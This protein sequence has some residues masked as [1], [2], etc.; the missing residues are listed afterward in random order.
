MSANTAF[1]K[2]L[3]ADYILLMNELDAWLQL[4][5]T[6]GVGP[7][8]F[9]KLLLKFGDPVAVFKASASE[10]T[11]LRLRA[12]TVDALMSPDASLIKPDLQWLENEQNHVLT[13]AMPQY[14][15]QLREIDDAPA[16][17]Y[18][19]GDP[20][21]LHTNQLGMVGSRTPTAQGAEN[22][23]Q[24]AVHMA[25]RGLV[26]T[27][28]LAQG[29]DGAAHEGALLGDGLTIAVC[30]TGLDRVYP[31]Q[32]HE[33][34]H[35]IAQEGALISEFPIG[36]GPRAE[37]FPRR[38]RIISGLSLGVLV[39]EAAERSGS[40]IS[41]RLASEQGREVFAVPGSIHN[42]LARGCHQLIRNGA[43]L[44]ES[45]A[46]VLEELA[47]ILRMQPQEV[48]SGSDSS[49]LSLSET[50]DLDP[51]YQQLLTVMGFDPVTVDILVERSGLSA[52]DVA[53]MLVIL[54][55]EGLISPNSDGTYA[56]VASELPQ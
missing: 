4:H 56:Q 26:I 22:A 48:Q 2:N 23:K 8:T 28:G 31:A 52:A 43:K 37:N 33:L 25:R 30:G 27:S 55:L 46:D 1:N 51:E 14:P 20:D 3:A 44:V 10:F 36:V 19:H 9:S 41:A 29:V 16:L 6:P 40:L 35:R 53:S 47:D 39:V 12:A 24:F 34:A 50:L 7:A 11:G 13:L 18:V 38:N 15:S 42:P 17:L 45:G 54:E 21:V 5:R 49:I 32:H